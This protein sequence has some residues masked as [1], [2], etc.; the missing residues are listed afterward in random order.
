MSPYYEKG[1]APKGLHR[2]MLSTRVSCLCAHR[3]LAISDKVGREL[4]ETVGFGKKIDTVYVSVDYHRFAD[5]SKG[6]IRQ[7]LGFDKSHII[8]TSVG[9]AIPVKGWD[10]AIKAFV[11]VYKQIPNARMVLVGDRTSSEYYNQLTGLIKQYEMEKNIKFTG[12][13]DDIPEILKASDIFI[14]PS[15][16]EGMGLALIE[17]MAAGLPCVAARVGGIPEVMN[18]GKGGLLYEREGVD[19][20]ARHLVRLIEDQ[21]LRMEIASQASN[22]ARVFSMR[23]YVDKVFECYADLLGKAAHT[24]LSARIREEG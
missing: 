16:S 15:R 5:A 6:N 20:L 1:I 24:T 7:E 10:V 22:R 2:L 14:F 21:T 12:K 18:H 19:A 9:H 17:A 8:I 23:A 3:I 13:R 11:Q 4:I